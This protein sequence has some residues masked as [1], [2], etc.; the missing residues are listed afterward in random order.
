[1]ASPVNHGNKQNLADQIAPPKES[2]RPVFIDKETARFYAV[3][4]KRNGIKTSMKRVRYHIGL[5]KANKAH[6]AHQLSIVQTKN[7]ARVGIIKF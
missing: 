2:P 7:I 1:M 5:F 6:T 4:R 3:E